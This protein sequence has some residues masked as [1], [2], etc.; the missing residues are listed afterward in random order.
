[1][2]MAHSPPRREGRTSSIS[3]AAHATRQRATARA[4]APRLHLRESSVSR[5]DAEQQRKILELCLDQ[6][7]I[8]DARCRPTEKRNH[9]S[10]NES[11]AHRRTPA[12]FWV[13]A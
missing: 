5:G 6:W 12:L 7:I 4:Y 10:K 9:N 3:S 2:L 11:T 1:M 13:R 8:E